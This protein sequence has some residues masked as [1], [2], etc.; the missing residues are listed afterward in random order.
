M[1]VQINEMI[2]RANIVES[3]ESGNPALPQ[4]PASAEGSKADIVKECVELVLEILNN[5]NQR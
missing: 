4:S 1:P 5:K 2:I 3:A